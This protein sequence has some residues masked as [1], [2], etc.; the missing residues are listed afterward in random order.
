MRKIGVTILLTLFTTIS[1]S[2]LK[3]ISSYSLFN[4]PSR[5]EFFGYKFE[6]RNN[7]IYLSSS[8][9]IQ[10][11]DFWGQIV[12]SMQLTCRDSLPCNNFEFEV[13]K[14]DKNN[15]EQLY[16]TLEACQLVCIADGLNTIKK[17]SL[18]EILDNRNDSLHYDFYGFCID[19]KKNIYIRHSGAS[20]VYDSNHNS[21]LTVIKKDTI[22]T[23]ELPSR[24]FQVNF[25]VY[26]SVA[27]FLTVRLEGS[28]LFLMNLNTYDSIKFFNI[29]KE[30]GLNADNVLLNRL[31]SF[32][33]K[34]CV[35]VA[36]RYN[37]NIDYII[38]VDLSTLRFEKILQIGNIIYDAKYHKTH[39]VKYVGESSWGLFIYEELPNRRMYSLDNEKLFV[40]YE[41]K[42]IMCIDT[43]NSDFIF[44]QT[45]F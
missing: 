44:L 27:V 25:K 28:H 24:S 1:H 40:L 34:K 20:G 16:Y 19:E 32:D 7:S 5:N 22:I 9:K 12:D 2:Q 33:G 31:I 3:K 39:K 38:Q 29:N 15:A 37:S 6:V 8:G 23:R 10:K 30:L 18:N 35:F 11:L 43:I 26:D 17:I 4:H 21:Y 45:P 36:S 14:K 41:S 42:G 13:T